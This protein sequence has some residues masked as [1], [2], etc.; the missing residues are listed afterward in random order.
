MHWVKT[1]NKTRLLVLLAFV[2]IFLVS[3]VPR[4]GFEAINPDAVNWHY[5]SEQ[6]VVGLKHQ[7]WGKTYQHYHPGVMLMWLT[8]VPI[9]V[10]KQV[11]GVEVYD[12][13][14]FY[15]FHFVAKYALVIFQLILSLLIIYWLSKILEFKKSVLAM[16]IFSFE[17]FIIGNS[18]M[19]HMDIIFTLFVF[20][21]LVLSNL[22]IKDEKNIWIVLSGVFCAFSFLT[23]SVGIGL[24]LFLLGFGSLF[25]WVKTKD[26]GKIIKYGFFL[27]LSFGITTFALFPALWDKPF[28]VLQNIFSEG[29]R[30]GVRNGHDQIVFGKSVEAAGWY[31]YP[32]ILILKLSPFILLGVVAYLLN[33]VSVA[34]RGNIKKE[35]IIF[36]NDKF[37]G[38]ISYSFI[39]YLGYFLVMSFPSKKI[40][41]YMITIFPLLSVVAG[42]GL[43]HVYHKLKEKGAMVFKIGFVS[44]FILM[45]LF[46]IYPSLKQHPYQFTYASPIFGGAKNAN[47]VIGQKSFGVGIF[48]VK[49]HLQSRYGSGV[50]VGFI[51]TKPIKSIYSNSLVSDIRVNGVSDYDVMVLAINEQI[52]QKVQESEVEFIKDSSIYINGLEYWRFYVKKDK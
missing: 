43:L 47:N 12:Q 32:L 8:G 44:I 24:L 50:E 51:D 27:L 15:A 29:Q 4:L 26:W 13:F 16:A 48:E 9:E 2:A 7:I 41:R 28:W 46:V 42:F 36:K 6:F 52:P 40:D 38:L 17:P 49:E 11:S 31:F 35:I 3:R 19:F 34:K 21:A 1:I 25:L 14:S 39:F 23:R 30:I 33:L 37:I 22:F 45:A 18:R 5:R 10:F 20:A